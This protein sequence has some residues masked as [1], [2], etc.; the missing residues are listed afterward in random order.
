VHSF[1]SVDVFHL[2]TAEQLEGSI[3]VTSGGPLRASVTMK[4][5]YGDSHIQS[6]VSLD[7]NPS[8]SDKLSLLRFENHVDWHSQHVF[9]K[10]QVPLAIKADAA[11]YDTQFGVISRPTH[12]NTTWDAAKFEVCAHKFVD[13]SE[14]GYGVALINNN[15]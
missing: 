7:A 15:K 10:F 2:E 4:F 1:S 5:S 3:E 14:F 6:V 12:R 13:L 9:L 11:I 8:C